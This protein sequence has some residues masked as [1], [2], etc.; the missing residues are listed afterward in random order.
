MFEGPIMSKLIRFAGNERGNIVITFA[1]A[2]AVMIGAASLGTEVASWYAT[3]RAMQNAADLGAQNAII[4]LK[5]VSNPATTDGYARKEAKSATAYH[6]YADGVKNAVVTVNIPPT[7]GS[8]TGSS[9]NH[10]AAEVVVAQPM[11]LTFASLF[12][13]SGPTITA[14]AVAIITPGGGDCVLALNPTASGA[15]TVWG[16]TSVNVGCGIAVD[17]NASDA[18]TTGG[19]ARLQTAATLTV[20]GG[21][22]LGHNGVQYGSLDSGNGTTIADPYASKLFPSLYPGCS[23]CTSV[24]KASLT[25]LSATSGTF[26]GGGVFSNGLTVSGTLTLSNGTY[27]IDQGDLVVKN[28]TLVTSNATIVLT[29]SVSGSNAG[30]F[31]VDANGVVNLTDPTSGLTSGIAIMQDRSPPRCTS[32]GNCSHMQSNPTITIVG[33]MYFPQTDFSM[34]GTPIWNAT[35][36]TQLIASTLYLQGNPVLSDT[37]CEGAGA[38]DFGPDVVKLAE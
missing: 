23:T 8:Y 11:P 31:V 26:T 38:S 35:A 13:S 14:R 30:N 29:S 36:C 19:N 28:A 33:A 5:N 25:S 18:L 32:S 1:V 3:K 4:S 9:Y 10:K 15:L 17:S 16:N 7:S 6:G 21:T 2:V 27:Y 12:M 24:S 22:S 37:N 20:N 34:Q